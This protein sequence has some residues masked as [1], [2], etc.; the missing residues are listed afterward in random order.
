[1]WRQ[2]PI[3]AAVVITATVMEGT[4]VAGI[5]HGLHKV[6]EVIFGCFAGIGVSLLMSKVWFIKIPKP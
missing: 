1:M 2:A 6:A 5:G 4:R 3:T